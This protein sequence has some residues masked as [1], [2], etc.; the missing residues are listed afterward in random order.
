MTPVSSI[1]RMKLISIRQR[2]FGRL[3]YAGNRS[4]A[5]GGLARRA[6]TG[7]GR[8][9]RRLISDF[10]NFTQRNFDVGVSGAQNPIQRFVH[11]ARRVAV[12]PVI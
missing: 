4:G 7:A 6:G 2:G 9:A 3:D 12:S 1:V 5:A 10:E 11:L 8:R